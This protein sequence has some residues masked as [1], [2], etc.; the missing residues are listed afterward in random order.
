LRQTIGF[1]WLDPVLVC[2]ITLVIIASV[3]VGFAVADGRPTVGIAEVG[4]ASGFVHVAGLNG[5][6][7]RAATTSAQWV[8]RPR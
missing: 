6:G 1:W 2:A 7:R 3:Y 4:V 5:Y 8:M